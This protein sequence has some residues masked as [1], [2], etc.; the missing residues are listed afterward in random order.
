MRIKKHTS[1]FVGSDYGKPGDVQVIKSERCGNKVIY[2][3]KIINNDIKMVKGSNKYMG[4]FFFL[5]EW[6]SV[7]KYYKD[8]Q[9]ALGYYININTP[10][11]LDNGTIIISDLFLD[12]WVYPDYSYKVLDRNEL[13]EALNKGVIQWELYNKILKTKEEVI[14]LIVNKRLPDQQII[15]YSIDK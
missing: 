6:Y 13:D 2:I 5:G 3:Y 4:S 15:D 11:K 1:D 14:Q 12:L 10:P 9:N 7:I 8:H